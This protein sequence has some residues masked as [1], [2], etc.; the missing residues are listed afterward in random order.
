MKKLILYLLTICIG[1]VYTANAQTV[2]GVITG[3]DDGQPLPG[4]N[5]QEKGT[6]TGTITD[7]NGSYTINV[8]SEN[9]VLVISFV[10]YQ[11]QEI[12]VGGQ[13]KI[14]LALELDA[15][16]I[17]EVV[18]VG[19]GT[20]KK[21]DVSGASITVS[22]DKITAN[23]G[24]NID[25]ALK[26]RA[27]GVNTINTSGQPGSAVSVSIRGQGTLS[28]NSQPLYIIDGVPVQNVG[29]GAHAVGLASLGNGSSGTFSGLSSIN[30][31]DI[32][33][34][35][36]L[37]DA[38]A[39]AIYGS[40]A[41][42]GVVL[43][44]T[45]NG[46]KGTAKFDYNFS[47][48]MQEQAKR[49]EVL[50]LQEF[51]QYSND[52]AAETDGRDPRVELMDPSI[53][54]QGTDWQSAV[55]QKAP[56]QSHQL[57]ASGG[58]E[59]LSYY[60][61]GS[62][63]DQEGT[64]IGSSFK[65][66]TTR[67]NLDAELN[68]WLKMGTQISFA[69]SFDKLGLTN[70][71]E[72]IISV[73]LRTSPD[74]PIYNT[75]GT[76]SGDQRE[77][78]AGQVNP[79]G[80]AMSE[81][82]ELKRINIR[83]SYFTEISFL[84]ELKLRSEISTD[85]T[86]S[87]AYYFNPTYKY[88]SLESISNTSSHQ[89]NQNYYWEFKNYLTYTKKFGEHSV[90]AMLGQETSEWNYEYLS[91]ASQG[92]PSN[93]VQQPGLGTPTTFVVGSGAGSGA[94]VSIYGR[95]YY[96]FKDKYNVTYT[97][98]RD[99]SS[100]FGPEN[101]WAPFNAFSL[102]WRLI[103]EE[104]MSFAKPVLSNLKL[105]GGWGQVGNDNI[106]SYKWG[107]G[108]GK[109]LTGLGQ[110]YRQTNIANPYVTW[111]RQQSTNIGLDLGFLDNRI[112]L[113]VEY[114]IKTSKDMLMSM[115]L[116]SYMGTSGNGSIRLNAPVGNFGEIQNNGLELSLNASPLKGDFK[117]DADLQVTIN[118]NKLISLQGT[119]ASGLAGYG[120]WSDVVAVSQI[121]S[122]LYSFYGYKVDGI[123]QSKEDLLNSPK[124]K[125][126]PSNGD[127][128]RESTPWV[129]DIKYKDL[130]GPQGVPDGV[131][132]EY[133]QTDIGSPLP[134]F[135]YGFNNRFTYKNFE[136][137][138]FVL[139]SYGNKVMNYMGRSLYGMESMWN[140]Q[141]SVVNDRTKLEPIDVNKVYPYVNEFGSTINNWYNDIN[142]VQISNPGQSMPRAI[143]GDPANNMRIS[144]RY[145][146]DGSYLRLQTVNVAYN[147]P[148][149]YL[150]KYK[151][152][153]IKMYINLQ[154]IYTFT[155]Y[156]GFDPEIGT[157]QTSDYVMGLDNGRYPSPRTYTFGINLTF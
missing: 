113:V 53:L 19:Y 13:S 117:W 128:K 23:V 109:M 99:G 127:L 118:H 5:I 90:N 88:G 153:G 147:V 105:R 140:N 22:S 45:K 98:R 131:I 16:G 15:T 143:A 77:G 111:E 11:V 50:S 30:P 100:N 48:G 110:G 44:T 104:F 142:N 92:L 26:G 101:R 149:Q 2:T 107:A 123:Y 71:T 61:S 129:G 9:S 24:A 155:N 84:P 74:V 93:V 81:V 67:V 1:F 29:Q 47:Y 78:S 21:T 80:K 57:S 134:K 91:G 133:D 25:Q 138:I 95:V 51:A 34:M 137:N 146:E 86:N 156:S 46:K 82:N 52:Y 75:D 18:V 154:N 6:S 125:E 33:T 126:Y 40:R 31:D 135:T 72:G 41:A 69:N 108:I 157:S 55:F 83:A 60:V 94:R 49:M 114:Y 63:F 116:P 119:D 96:G 7:L 151:I 10:G 36:V 64:V 136:L 4:V 106:G 14:D 103:N 62:Y 79:I 58:T 132:D 39:T 73:A 87:N 121:G 27:A 59:K 42:N 120:Q 112:N 35:E 150:S 65:R 76:F 102:S 68:K 85:L 66:Y 17:D 89:Y 56:I 97:Y 115:Q 38:S 37:K 122:P 54:G 124:P 43:I 70:S 141:L 12:K 8:T 152:S 148:A 139:G 28:Q 145:I 130:S 32:L 144:D 20:M 3:A